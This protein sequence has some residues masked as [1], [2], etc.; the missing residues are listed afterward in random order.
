M[1]TAL[2]EERVPTTSSLGGNRA[3]GV[4]LSVPH[5]DGGCA[6]ETQPPLPSLQTEST[7]SPHPVL[8]QG[9]EAPGPSLSPPAGE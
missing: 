6:V 7:G 1:G 4:P 8:S 2:P 9:A 5:A 3:I